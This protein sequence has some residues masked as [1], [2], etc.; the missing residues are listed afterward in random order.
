MLSQSDI[1]LYLRDN[2]E[3]LSSRFGIRRIGLFG[4]FA[5]NQQTETS[6]IDIL[7][8]MQEDVNDL[9][10]KRLSLRDMLELRFGRHVDV[11]HEKAIRPIFRELVSREVIYA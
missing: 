4:S 2:R 11:C 8:D 6:D 10:G 7:I 3:M 5:R 1:L 9:F